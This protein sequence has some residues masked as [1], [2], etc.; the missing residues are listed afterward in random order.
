M[1][2]YVASSWRNEHQPEVVSALRAQGHSVYDF[3]N[4]VHGGF[5]WGEIDPEWKQWTPTDYTVNIKHPRAEQGFASDMNAL[6]TADACV[7]VLP[8]G[9]SASLEAGWA[10]GNGKPTAIL[11]D[12]GEPELMYKMA[13]FLATSITGLV[14]WANSTAYELELQW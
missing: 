13:E 6:K 5:H 2:I 14:V 7:M 8:C 1:R 4:P 3:R 9:R 11:L 12:T 10:I